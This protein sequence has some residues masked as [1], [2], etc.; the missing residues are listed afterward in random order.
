MDVARSP[1]A[2]A[3]EHEVVVADRTY[4]KVF[5]TLL[6]FTVLEY[7]FAGL[8]Q[9]SFGLLVGGLVCMALVKALLVALYFMHVR[10]E[11]RWVYLLIVPALFLATVLILALYPDIGAQRE[12]TTYRPMS[13]P[14]ASQARPSERAAARPLP[15][16]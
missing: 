10:I 3:G 15:A 6:V 16:G 9:E 12:Q 13:T 14:S 8:A 1:E 2:P 7:A 4:L 5:L 11:G